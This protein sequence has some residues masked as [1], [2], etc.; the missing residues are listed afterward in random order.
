MAHEIRN[1]LTVLKMLYHSLDL[2]FPEG[3][4]RAKDARIIDEKI[5][6]LNRIVE[7]ILD[8]ARTAEPQL[9]PVNL[10]QLIEELGLLVRHKLKHQNIQ[11]AH[12]FEPDL[13]PVM[14]AATQLEQAF[15]NLIL[16]AAEAMP[17]GGTL[18]ITSRP[19]RLPRGSAQPTH[20]AVEFRDTGQGMSEEQ[21]RRAFTSLLSTT[22]AKGTGLG[23][24]IV[25]RVVEAHR[26]TIKIRS[27]LGHGTTVSVILPL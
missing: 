5:E 25:A 1:P 17:G 13:P 22:K 12:K 23:L 19:L 10:N 9:A 21:R 7:Q 11:W 4:P 15:L 20:V 18:T 14:G 24:A 26:G 27:R 16:N 8:F 2:R 6:Q 3:D